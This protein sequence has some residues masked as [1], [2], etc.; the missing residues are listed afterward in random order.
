MSGE[1]GGWIQGLIGSFGYAGV[2]LLLFVENV[3]PPIPSEV[4]LP[5]VGFWVSRGELR[6][7][8]ALIA[9]VLG[10]LA[11]ALLLYALG[12]LGGRPLVLRYGRVLHVK[13]S[14][15]DRADEWFDC[16]G[17]LVVLVGRMVPLA[18]S[19]VSIPAGMSKMPL[20]RFTLLTVLGCTAWDA[21]LIG[22]GWLL[23]ENWERV[24]RLVGSVSD[25][26]LVA[27]LVAAV[28]L[29]IWW[30]RRRA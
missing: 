16:Y 23:G 5:L 14:D 9:A 30:R 13:K 11:G 18:R 27:V 10:S 21:L 15:L 26:V 6:F 22:A 2:A 12:R 8:W 7:V 28:G 3:F 4:I 25:V 20:G 24:S 17:D 1:L 29:A 19:V